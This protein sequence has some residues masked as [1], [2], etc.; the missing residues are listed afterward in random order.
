MSRDP[1]RIGRK[2]HKM[3]L[4][5]G[6]FVW[7]HADGRKTI[8]FNRGCRCSP[9]LAQALRDYREDLKAWVDESHRLDDA[10]SERLARRG[11]PEVRSDRFRGPPG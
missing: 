7:T 5:E 2:V 4:S 1:Y 6:G 9:D 3:L 10:W 8:H 11:V